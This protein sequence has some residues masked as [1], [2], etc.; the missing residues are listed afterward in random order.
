MERLTE[1]NT[2]L[3]KNISGALLVGILVSGQASA[4]YNDLV[5]TLETKGTITADEAAKL[6]IVEVT[7]DKKDVLGL[8]ITGRLHLQAGY[9]DQKNDVNSGD[10]STMEVRRARI[11]ISGKFP[12]NIS[13]AV[14]ANVKPSDTSVSSATLKWKN[15]DMFNVGA[16]FDKP[17]SSLEENTSSASILTVERSNVNNIIAAPGETTGLWVYGEMAPF[18]YHIGIYNDEGVDDA[19]NS[20][21]VEAEYLFNAQGGVKFDLTEKSELMAMVTYLQSDDPNG[22]VGGDFESVTTASLQYSAGPIEIS[23][24]YLIGDDN[25]DETSGFYITPA[26]MVNDKLQAVVRFEMVESDSSSGV[27]A[28]SRYG[29]RTD[30]VVIGKDEDGKNI[31]ADKGDEYSA[32]YLGM[33][34]YTAKYQK[35]MFGIEF[36]ELKN[37]KAGTLDTTSLFGA[38][39]LRF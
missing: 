18:F 17:K 13:A 14:E 8:K 33:N 26:M 7:P 34:Y 19:R 22:N 30:T 24:E 12:G 11:G 37:T 5:K 32:L 4:G 38:Y 1:M 3:L 36:S 27:R 16:G 39:R 29:R 6:K 10:W 2:K 35:I 21:N 23:A 25:G 15:S 28:S 9:L 20:S 31:V